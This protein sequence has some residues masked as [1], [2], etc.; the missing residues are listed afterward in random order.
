MGE[1]VN[2]APAIDQA[3]ASANKQS[4]EMEQI[5]VTIASTGRPVMIA[6]PRDA[7]D[8]ELLEVIG[9]MATTLRSH[10]A[11]NKRPG[12]GRLVLPSH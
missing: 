7:T 1:K 9:W 4:V 8:S 3:I 11:T 2:G 6:F 5:T 10:V 12:A